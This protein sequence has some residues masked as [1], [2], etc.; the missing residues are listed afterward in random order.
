[1]IGP[2]RVHGESSS[3]SLERFET[4]QATALAAAGDESLH[5][6]PLSAPVLIPQCHIFLFKCDCIISERVYHI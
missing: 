2:P 6:K 3:S 5:R 4:Q 1:M